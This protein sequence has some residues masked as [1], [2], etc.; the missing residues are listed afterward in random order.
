MSEPPELWAFLFSNLIVLLFGGGMTALSLLAYRRS[1]TR[2]FRGAAVGFGLI[3]VGALTEAAYQL[4]LRRSYE[5]PGR[6]L[7]ALQTVE[8]VLIALGLAALF[9]SLREY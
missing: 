6:E 5:L 7:L 1:G 2:Q 8:G 3:T 9:Y 4:L